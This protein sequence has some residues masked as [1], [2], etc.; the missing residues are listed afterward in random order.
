MKGGRQ[1]ETQAAGGGPRR[2]RRGPTMIDVAAAAGVSQTTVSLVLNNAV[3]ARLST[4]TRQRVRDAAREL[5]YALP[6]HGPASPTARRLDGDRLHRRRDLHRPL[7][8]AAARR[9]ARAGLGARADRRP[10][11]SATATRTLEAA[12]LGAAAAPAAGRADLRHDPDPARP[13]AAGVLPG[14]DGAAELLRARTTRWPRWCRA[15]SSAATSR[16]CA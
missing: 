7:V 16:R 13:A 12:L 5:G 6:R 8:R 2:R 11:G 3:G 9:G 10:P 1:D 15:S 14:A 4:A